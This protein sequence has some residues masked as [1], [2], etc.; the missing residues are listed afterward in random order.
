SV[1]VLALDGPCNSTG[2]VDT[3]TPPVSVTRPDN[4]ICTLAVSG[5]EVEPPFDMTVSVPVIGPSAE[6]LTPT[7]TGELAPAPRLNVAPEIRL[8]PGELLRMADPSN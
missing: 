8:R 1:T 6:P 2:T 7:T 3:P 4:M 5:T